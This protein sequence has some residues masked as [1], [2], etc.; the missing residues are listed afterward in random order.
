MGPIRRVSLHAGSHP[1][2][3]R[4]AGMAQQRTPLLR[5]ASTGRVACC[6]ASTPGLREACH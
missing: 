3:A 1:H 2:L 6:G 5:A 4:V